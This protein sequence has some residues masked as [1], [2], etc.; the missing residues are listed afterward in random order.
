[1]SKLINEH[2]K[3][4]FKRFFEYAF[5]F[6][7]QYWQDVS[8]W[9]VLGKVRTYEEDKVFNRLITSIIQSEDRLRQIINDPE[10]NSAKELK[11]Y[12]Y[13]FLKDMGKAEGIQEPK[14]PEAPE[15]F[16]GFYD[17]TNR[18]VDVIKSSSKPSDIRQQALNRLKELVPWNKLP[19]AIFDREVFT[20]GKWA[21]WMTRSSSIDGRGSYKNI[22]R[23]FYNAKMLEFAKKGSWDSF[24]LY[25]EG[26]MLAV[27]EAPTV[28][29]P[30]PSSPT[31]Q[32]CVANPPQW[33]S[34]IK[35][36]HPAGMGVWNA[37]VARYNREKAACDQAATDYNNAKA[38]YDNALVE[39]NNVAKCSEYINPKWK[40]Y[41]Q[42][43]DEEFPS[44][45]VKYER[46]IET[47]VFSD[48]AIVKAEDLY[49]DNNYLILQ[50]KFGEAKIK[51]VWN[52]PEKLLKVIE[53]KFS[54][55]LKNIFAIRLYDLTILTLEEQKRI[56]AGLRDIY[57]DM[58]YG[59][60]FVVPLVDTNVAEVVDKSM[61][62]AEETKEIKK[63]K[64]EL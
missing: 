7:K 13:I 58:F 39:Y 62:G 29:L 64:E 35:Y 9:E 11:Y 22:D 56:M 16:T 30:K 45:L 61:L 52:S 18:L 10:L 54:G 25:A 55:E 28:S 5:R 60:S 15:N 32:N 33:P 27:G 43:Q 12:A 2:V 44:L 47:A 37:E 21:D 14:L 49:S 40:K 3:N 51:E 38:A 53:G 6:N 31:K 63:A 42:E 4:E 8:G 36:G 50:N 1:M 20:Q 26:Y 41:R 24:S 23:N 57:E 46:E 48:S 59:E 34:N 17:N 19:T